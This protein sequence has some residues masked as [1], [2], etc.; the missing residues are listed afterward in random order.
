[1]TQ[2]HTWNYPEE[3]QCVECGLF[4]SSAAKEESNKQRQ[5]QNEAQDSDLDEFIFVMPNFVIKQLYFQYFNQS[6]IADAQIAP[7]AVDLI[8][9]IKCL[10]NV[11]FDN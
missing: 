11:I 9:K 7:R 4:A 6:L 5:E 10:E 8:D 1:M 3:T 2:C